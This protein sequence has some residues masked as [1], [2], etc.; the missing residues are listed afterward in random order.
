[1]KMA[2]SFAWL[3][4][5]TSDA[6][7]CEDVYK[8]GFITTKHDGVHHANRKLHQRYATP[9][10]GLSVVCVLPV[11][12]G[13]DAERDLFERLHKFRVE[14][15]RE[16]FKGFLLHDILPVMQDVADIW[17]RT[18][19]VRMGE[20][21]QR[22]E[23][24]AVS[25][26]PHIKR[27]TFDRLV[28]S[29]PNTPLSNRDR[30]FAAIDADKNVEAV[31]ANVATEH[32]DRNLPSELVN[33]HNPFAA[34][35]RISLEC[36]DAIRSICGILG[37][38]H[39]LDRDTIVPRHKIEDNLVALNRACMSVTTI[40]RLKDRV[41]SRELSY[42]HVKARID[43]VLSAWAGCKLGDVQQQRKDKR[44]I[45]RLRICMASGRRGL[46]AGLLLDG[47]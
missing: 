23:L 4:A 26:A 21:G 42:K 17:H 40:M 22:Q 27:A 36:V 12:D 32:V 19:M 30:L 47:E 44:P 43:K 41:K 45:E 37:L 35:I 20:E 25:H 11:S 34:S 5:V 1:M 33:R 15:R 46:V 28:Q 14:S 18:V 6:Y 7:V 38:V 16:F 3:Y 24:G 31:F 13:R 9:L 39:S 2:E 29:F 8:L 10:L